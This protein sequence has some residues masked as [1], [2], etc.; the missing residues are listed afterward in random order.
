MCIWDSSFLFFFSSPEKED[1][2][3]AKKA[4]YEELDL[5]EDD[6]NEVTG[7]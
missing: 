3:A 1:R 2:K 6:D 5:D 4:R 7:K